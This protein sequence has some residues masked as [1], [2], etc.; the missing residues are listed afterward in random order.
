MTGAPTQQERLDAIRAVRLAAHDLANVC[1][2]IVGGTQ[3]AVSLPTVDTLGEKADGLLPD[4][5]VKKQ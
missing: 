4:Q 2:A 5:G 3:M 1:A